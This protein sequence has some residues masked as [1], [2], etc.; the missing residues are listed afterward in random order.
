[1]ARILVVDDSVV[2]RRN[3]V[4]ILT[5]AG[6]TIVGEAMNGGQAH[7]MY[8]T[9]LPDL[10]TMDITMPGI[11]GIDAVKLII[12]DYPDAKII[13]V[14]AL[15]QRNMVFDALE[16]GAKH[17]LIKPVTPDSVKT[18]VQ[19]VLGIKLTNLNTYESEGKSQA[20]TAGKISNEKIESVTQ[21]PF[22]IES[23]NNMFQIKITKYLTEESFK[24]LQQAIQGLLFVKPLKVVIDFG[25][26]EVLP[27]PL[28]EKIGEIVKAISGAN[29]ILKIVAQNNDFTQ[30]IR[31]KKIE[32]L[33]DH[34]S[35]ELNNSPVNKEI[36][37]TSG[38]SSAET[39]VGLNELFPLGHK[40]YSL[41]PAGAIDKF[42][43]MKKITCPICNNSI[44]L[45]VVRFTKLA[46][47]KV[48]PDFRQHFVGFEPL[49][50]S[51]QICPQCNYAS[52]VE[53]FDKITEK[54]KSVI[55]QKLSKL[56]VE[57]EAEFS[58]Q[59][60]IDQVFTSYY[61][62]LYWLKGITTDKLQEGKL[63]LRLAW[64]YEDVN[65][66]ELSKM[67]S[68]K[69]L[70]L[71]KDLYNNSRRQTTVE[72]DQR[73]T[74]LLGELCMRNDLRDEAQQYFRD[75]IVH[76]GGNK[77]MNETARDRMRDIRE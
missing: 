41:E 38:T 39:D 26:L 63:W 55:L 71:Y 74:M 42:I 77:V 43:Y 59:R 54:V 57:V 51:V 27:H 13:M 28:L 24:S 14:S 32:G 10:V 40:H 30:L 66:L 60:N 46:I 67:A 33:S 16:Q 19:K 17:Y 2:M 45:Q 1:M 44:E 70:T 29:G 50:Y 64:L 76:K 3:L 21:Q 31:D 6:H 9:Y 61:L 48:D 75:T 68:E 12:K 73:L 36:I 52:L 72:Q 8:R 15:N 18:V 7:L 35:T 62:A 22:T 37:R 20:E 53:D 4:N 34:L 56:K 58:A 23:I 69:A 5:Q 65:D 25:N 11:N 47:D 49:W